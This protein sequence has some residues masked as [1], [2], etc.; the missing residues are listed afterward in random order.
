MP[1][2]V[3][4]DRIY[5]DSP[6]AE[7]LKTIMKAL[8]YKIN[9]DTGSKK[10]SVVETIK[11][12]K[13]L[14]RSIVSVPQGRIDL[15]PE[16][17]QIL[18]KRTKVSVPFPT[19]RHALRDDQQVIYNEVNDSCFIN[20]LPGWGKTFTAL[21]IAHK[22][23]QRTLVITHT[24]ALRD[25]WIGEVRELFGME[26][27]IIGGG[28]FDIEDR[29]IVVGNIQSIVKHLPTLN[30]LFGTII[31][32]EAHHCP[33]TT[34]S[35]TVDAFRAR[36]R[37]AL[38]GTMIRKDGKH[39]IFGDYFGTHVLK[40]PQSNTLQPTIR[41]VKSGITLKPGVTWVEKINDLCENDRYQ[42]FIAGIAK[43]EIANGHSVLIIADRVE[44]LQKVK[45]NVGETCLLVTGSEGDRDQA[46]QQIL[47]GEKKAIAGS[48]QIFSEGISIN[49]LSCVILAVPMSNDSLL[50]QII[51][52]VQRMYD[53]KLNPLVVDINFAGYADKKQNND[54]LGLY[55]RKGWQ[56]TTV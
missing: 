50:E 52:R 44:F 22:F 4:S 38:S 55:M 30:N 24:A 47:S 1:K 23:G 45:E 29:A 15:V 7:H 26:P 32:D 19:P 16:G 37:I 8:T 51:G 56:I 49:A 40:P 43:I 14:E 9:K 17:Y 12:Y 35:S 20:A 21:H 41:I 39:V 13:I 5:M 18:D 48:R 36:Y 54:R 2:A 42:E 28:E 31:L 27:G 6:G 25:Q 10:F 33:A 34:F 3:I 11:N 46:K 53:G